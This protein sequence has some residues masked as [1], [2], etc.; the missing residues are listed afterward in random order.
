MAL[1]RKEYRCFEAAQNLKRD[2][3][4]LLDTGSD[5]WA[6]SENWEAVKG[7]NAMFKGMLEAV[8]T[9]EDPD[10]DEP[11]RNERD[12]RDIWPFDLPEE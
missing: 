6:P 7:N 10:A 2:L 11:I 12:L 5:G 3:S 8:L 9:N 4:S 1:H